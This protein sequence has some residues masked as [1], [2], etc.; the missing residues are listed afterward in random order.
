MAAG[1]SL[2]E[3]CESQTDRYPLL[4]EQPVN[5]N[6]DEHVIDV[7]EVLL[8]QHQWFMEMGTMKIDLRQPQML[9]PLSHQL[10][11]LRQIL[12]MLL[13]IGELIIMVGAVEVL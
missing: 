7:V 10:L 8:L 12:E 3:Q 13:S 5:G 11:R 6:A 9:L 4:M 1:S 2:E